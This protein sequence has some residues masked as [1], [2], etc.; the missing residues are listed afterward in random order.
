MDVRK[1]AR[2]YYVLAG[3]VCFCCAISRSLSAIVV[4]P[5]IVVPN[6]EVVVAVAFTHCLQLYPSLFSHRLVS[7]LLQK[8]FRMEI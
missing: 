3:N 4:N 7:N 6:S 8:K 2:Q 1:D 5:V